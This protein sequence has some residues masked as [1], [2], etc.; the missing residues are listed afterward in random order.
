MT[1]RT[2]SLPLVIAGGS[3]ARRS[4]IIPIGGGQFRKSPSQPT[5]D[6]VVML[7]IRIG[8]NYERRGMTVIETSVWYSDEVEEEM[9]CIILR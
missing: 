9:K 2:N 1:T 6:F 5:T 8:D 7:V 3:C 4:S